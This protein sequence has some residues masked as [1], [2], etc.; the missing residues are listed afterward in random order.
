MPA[1]NTRKALK[2]GSVYTKTFRGKP[3]TMKVVQTEVGI[4]YSVGNS[5][6]KTPSAAAKSITKNEINGWKFW[7]ID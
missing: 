2:T 1:H 7:G 5:V 4:G 3:Y 6:F